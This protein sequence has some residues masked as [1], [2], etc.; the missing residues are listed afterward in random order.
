MMNLE[1][2]IK[3]A[4]MFYKNSSFAFTKEQRQNFLNIINKRLVVSAA[5]GALIEQKRTMLEQINRVQDNFIYMLENYKQFYMK[6]GAGTGKTWIAMKLARK[7]LSMGLDVLLLCYSPILARFIRTEINSKEISVFDFE[8][9]MCRTFNKS[10]FEINTAEDIIDN[11]DD[12]SY[13]KYDAIIV[14]KVKI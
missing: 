3:K 13:K 7:Y 5:A 2:K 6:G 14:M 11:I 9:L 12:Y 10:V 4:F 1:D 8:D